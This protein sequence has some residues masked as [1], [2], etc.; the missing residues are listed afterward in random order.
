MIPF[1][2]NNQLS[3]AISTNQFNDTLMPKKPIKPRRRSKKGIKVRK[4]RQSS[5][6][7][8]AKI[9]ISAQNTIHSKRER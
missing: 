1:P 6:E 3:R 2:N 5:K 8:M 4:S 9:N 7:S